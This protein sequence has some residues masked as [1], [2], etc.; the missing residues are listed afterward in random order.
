MPTPRRRIER[1]SRARPR[2]RSLA[3]GA[4]ASA[5]SIISAPSRWRPVAVQY[6]SSAA[7]SRSARSPS[8]AAIQWS[9]AARKLPS[10]RSISSRAGRGRSRAPAAP[11]VP[12]ARGSAR[13]GGGGRRPPRRAR[14]LGRGELAYDL[15]LRHALL[16]DP[17]QALGHQR[18]QHGERRARH[19]LRGV[20]LGAADEHGERA[21]RLLLVG[22]E[23][24]EAPLERRADRPLARRR[25]ARPALQ[26]RQRVASRATSC[27]GSSSP[28][29]PA[30]SSIASGSPSS[31]RHSSATAGALLSVSPKSGR[32]SR[33]RSTNSAMASDTASGATGRHCS[34]RSR[35]GSRL[36]ASTWSR[37][38]AATSSPSSGRG[39]EDVL[40]VV[41]D[42][43]GLRAAEAAHERVLIA[44]AR[45]RRHLHGPGQRAGDVGGGR[46]RGRGRRHGRRRGTRCASA[47]AASMAMRVL[48]TPPG[49]VKVTSRRSAITPATAWRSASR[50]TVGVGG[51]GG[52]SGA[53]GAATRRDRGPPARARA[54][55][56]PAAGPARR[57]AGAAPRGRP[58]APRRAGPRRTAPASAARRA[59][60]AAAPLPRAVRSRPARR[61]RAPAPDRR[62]CAPRS[63]PSAAPRAGRSPAARTLRSADRP[64][65]RLATARA[66]RG[67]LRRLRGRAV[68]QCLASLLQQRLEAVGVE[69]A[70]PDAQLIAGLR[71]HQRLGIA[72]RGPDPRH[73][74]THRLDRVGGR[75]LAPQ[76]HRQP[77][78]AHRLVGVKQQHRQQRP[79]LLAAQRDTAITVA[80]LQRAEDQ[81]LH[82]P[83][84]ARYRA[85]C[86][87]A[88]SSSAALRRCPQRTPPTS[89]RAR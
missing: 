51:G 11:G 32:R 59:A 12:R 33:A 87:R 80:H 22:I 36:V 19:R 77:L 2:A 16:A 42:Q 79:P 43:Q 47:R 34:P 15:E 35:S 49:P 38:H 69:L 64:G 84:R 37:G 10:S 29:R 39:V 24:R 21:E 46:P 25:V 61:P 9:S 89:R 58:T 8:P 26:Q 18:V 78:R 86:Y 57:R 54:A 62:R 73:V 5:A 72:E 14:Q 65:R 55:P 70:R 50:P 45:L 7:A 81:E 56:V 4:S 13:R 75:I 41:D 17:G 82:F 85:E 23:Q 83:H 1:A 74:H 20:D 68:G 52:P 3:P 71:R 66:R 31:R 27:P 76:S 40:D 44:L 60:R 88:A 67:A 48:P 63:R 28:T 30:A 53:S 6:G